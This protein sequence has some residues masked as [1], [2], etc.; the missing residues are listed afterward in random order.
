MLGILNK[1]L[2][3]EIY[4]AYQEMIDR[5]KLDFVVIST[6]ADSH[7]DII[8]YAMEKDLH[9]F[10]EKPFVLNTDEGGEIL[11]AIQG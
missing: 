2:D 10:C 11:T 7:S 6:P 5:C 3:V 8:Q 4:S 9:I 1:Y